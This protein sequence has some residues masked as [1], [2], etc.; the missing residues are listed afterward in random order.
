MKKKKTDSYLSI[1]MGILTSFGIL[2]P[3]L[4][5]FSK[6]YHYKK[7][8]PDIK[9]SKQIPTFYVH[10]F[11][12]NDS[13]TQQMVDAAMS[14]SQNKTFLRVTIDLLGNIDYDGDLGDGPHPIVQVVFKDRFVGNIGIT[15]Y[16]DMILPAL[17]NT[18][19]FTQFNAV[20]HSLGATSL[21]LE[22]MKKHRSSHF[23]RLNKL[24][25]LAG[26]FD[27]VVYLGDFPNVNQLTKKGRPILMN[28]RYLQLLFK[29]HRFPKNVR[30]LNMYGNVDD[31]SNTDKYI[32]VISARSIKYILSP[33]VKEFHEF[34]LLGKFGEH[35]LIHDNRYAID[36]LNRF[37][38]SNEME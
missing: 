29:R 15:R 27:G 22:A 20:G 33:V 34:E 12:G 31:D 26:P 14:Y 7:R 36:V 17:A 24:V 21:V 11:R 13:S 23:P 25:L 1:V 30:I 9:P 3:F 35:S 8:E 38:Y 5:L 16:L 37:L 4:R 2:K 10:G 18:Y 28:L 19:H 6:K 32:S